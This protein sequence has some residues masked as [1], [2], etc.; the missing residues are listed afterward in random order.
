MSEHKDLKKY[1]ITL[2]QYLNM[3]DSLPKDLIKIE[4]GNE[5]GSIIIDSIEMYAHIL[6]D[7]CE[8]CGNTLFV[9]LEYDAEF[10][11]EC[12]EWKWGPC[13]DV[14]CSYCGNRPNRPVV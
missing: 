6:T 5:I 10:C 4:D 12:N 13:G 14:D 1:K 3:K 11:F 7:K 9:H 8:T 2:A